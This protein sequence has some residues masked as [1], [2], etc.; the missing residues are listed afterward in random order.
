MIRYA[1]PVQT[2]ITLALLIFAGLVLIVILAAVRAMA[3]TVWLKVGPFLIALAVAFATAAVLLSLVWARLDH[4]AAPWATASLVLLALVA[5][6]MHS[7]KWFARNWTDRIDPPVV[8]VTPAVTLIASP[9]SHTTFE[10]LSARRRLWR[11]IEPSESARFR[12][13]LDYLRMTLAEERSSLDFSERAITQ[14]WSRAPALPDDEFRDLMSSV[15]VWLRH[16]ERHLTEARMM[17]RPQQLM[18]CEKA[19]QSL[20]A[21]AV[22]S[23]GLL[24]K[25]GNL[26]ADDMNMRMDHIANL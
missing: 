15:T 2:I 6:Y 23:R 16:T 11:R 13:L 26:E 24:A 1:S 25:R 19:V 3:R 10:P 5:S 18:L 4:S 20:E 17:S 9:P 8:P 21:F 22:R 12:H 7:R 14:M